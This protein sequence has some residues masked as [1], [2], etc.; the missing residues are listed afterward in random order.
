[1]TRSLREQSQTFPAFALSLFQSACNWIQNLVIYG[2]GCNKPHLWKHNQVFGG[3]KTERRGAASHFAFFEEWL[4][5]CFCRSVFAFPR[6]CLYFWKQQEHTWGKAKRFS[7]QTEPYFSS[8]CA[9]FQHRSSVG[10]RNQT[11]LHH[12]KC[13]H[14]CCILDQFPDKPLQ[15]SKGIILDSCYKE[16]DDFLKN[17]KISVPIRSARAETSEGWHLSCPAA[18]TGKDS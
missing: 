6:V 10:N 11:D 4:S 14:F 5:S 3:C 15:F 13:S 7:Q 17:R 1:M 2:S 18:A 8:Y 12:L 9:T 16:A